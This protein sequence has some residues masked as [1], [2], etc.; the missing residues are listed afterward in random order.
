MKI[1]INDNTAVSLR[2]VMK[3]NKGEILENILESKPV[4]YLHGS[5]NILPQLEA[6][7]NGLKKGDTTSL[8]ITDENEIFYFDVTIDD[9]RLATET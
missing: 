4:Q 1:Q 3:N 7:L 2:Y 9:V 6:S 8:S 5:E